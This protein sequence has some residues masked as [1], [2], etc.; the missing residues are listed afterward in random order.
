MTTFTGKLEL[1]N[2]KMGEYKTASFP[3]PQVAPGRKNVRFLN[4]KNVTV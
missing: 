3:T 4:T 2:R 1:C